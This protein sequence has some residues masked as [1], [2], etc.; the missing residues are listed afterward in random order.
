MGFHP[1]QPRKALCSHPTLLWSDNLLLKAT[2]ALSPQAG[3]KNHTQ[4]T[5]GS[6]ILCP[7]MVV[8]LFIFTFDSGCSR[9]QRCA[10]VWFFLM[11]QPALSASNFFKERTS[12]TE[13]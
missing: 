12:S 1:P 3:K 11:H 5:P 8:S 6:A 10:I 7:W 2:G 9:E 13:Y 4:N